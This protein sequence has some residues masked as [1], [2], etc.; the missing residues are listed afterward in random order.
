[1]HATERCTTC[2][3]KRKKK[4]EGYVETNG[5]LYV[6]GVLGAILCTY[7]FGDGSRPVLDD[8]QDIE[9]LQAKLEQVT[10]EVEH[11]I[12]THAQYQDIVTWVF[13]II[14]FFVIPPLVCF[15]AV[16]SCIRRKW[17]T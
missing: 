7:F 2:Q 5:G 4:K 15:V 13:L 10:A 17:I 8:S 16:L 12:A 14:P 6:I 3:R 1:M 9:S 11:T